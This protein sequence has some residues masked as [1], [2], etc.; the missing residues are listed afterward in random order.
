LANG[1]EVQAVVVLDESGHLTQTVPTYT[2][3]IKNQSGAAA[4]IHFDIFNATGSGK[5][6][7][8]RGI[9]ISPA[10]QVVQAA[11]TGVSPDFDLLR[12]S[13]V[14]TGGT[15]LTY[16]ASTFPNYHTVDTNNAALPAQITMRAA[17][18]GGATSSVA[19]I[20]QYVTQEETHAGAQMAQWQNALPVTAVGQRYTARE[21]QGYKLTQVT[22]GATG[23]FTFICQFTVV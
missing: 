4:K 21:G 3:V 14:G 10:I 2:L 23:N 20:P 16:N 15:V 18:T 12:T 9:W 13:T 17:T 5:I 19:C 8:L 22:A 11:T 1:T 7:E 6:V